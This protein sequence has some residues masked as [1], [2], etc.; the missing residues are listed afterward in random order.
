MAFAKYSTGSGL[1]LRALCL[2]AGQGLDDAA[3][4]L[5]RHGDGCVQVALVQS[6][7]GCC[8]KTC[9][10]TSTACMAE[11]WVGVACYAAATHACVCFHMHSSG[12]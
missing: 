8:M 6:L 2:V 9:A 7:F 4:L 12:V 5:Q 11:L 3:D 1:P 10:S